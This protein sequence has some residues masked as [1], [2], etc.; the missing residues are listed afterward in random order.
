MSSTSQNILER[1]MYY[2]EVH[3]K[4]IIKPTPGMADDSIVQLASFNGRPFGGNH[5]W[6]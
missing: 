1:D 3:F 4:F 2:F 6:F 5:D